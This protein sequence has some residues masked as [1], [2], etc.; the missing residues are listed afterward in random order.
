[1]CN[2]ISHSLLGSW[3]PLNPKPLDG[4]QLSWL[5][6]L[7]QQLPSHSSWKWPYSLFCLG[8]G[9]WMLSRSV[10]LVFRGGQ[11]VGEIGRWW[12]LLAKQQQEDLQ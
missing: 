6:G 2:G 3:G 1:M 7:G 12:S 9:L 4:G 5:D 8:I 11:V 10:A